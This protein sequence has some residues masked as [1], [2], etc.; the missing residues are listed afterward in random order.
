MTPL[1][2]VCSWT[3]DST[4]VGLSSPFCNKGL[5]KLFLGT[6]ARIQW[7]IAGRWL[8]GYRAQSQHSACCT[9]CLY[10]YHHFLTSMGPV[11]TCIVRHT[12]RDPAVCS[13]AWHWPNLAAEH[14]ETL[15]PWHFFFEV[16]DKQYCSVTVTLRCTAVWHPMGDDHTAVLRS[17]FP[18]IYLPT[19]SDFSPHWSAENASAKFTSELHVAKSSGCLFSLHLL[20]SWQNLPLLPSWNTLFCLLPAKSAY[21]DFIPSSLKAHSVCSFSLPL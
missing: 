21:L 9:F 2:D 6:V 3:R 11:D 10:H 15:H 13:S 17:H 8:A 14:L 7:E 1:P 19:Q 12:A 18:F 20:S 4:S 16:L 5:I